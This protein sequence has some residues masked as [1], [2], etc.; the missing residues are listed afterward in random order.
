MKEIWKD[1]RGY[2]GYYKVSNL[3]RVRS[4]NKILKSSLQKCGNYCRYRVNLYLDGNIK[5]YKVHRL[6]AQAFIKNPLNKPQVNHK[7]N[8]PL[9]NKINNLEWVTN[10]ENIIYC[11]NQRRNNIGEKNGRS[12]LKTYEVIKIRKL[13]KTKTVL[14]LSKKFKISRSQIRAILNKKQWK[15]V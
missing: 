6:V 9:N 11:K 3:G 4:N 7:D 10:Y 15:Y 8:N 1:V 12:K 5:M 2:E 14:C 13:S